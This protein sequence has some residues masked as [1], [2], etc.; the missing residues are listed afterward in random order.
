MAIPLSAGKITVSDIS[1]KLEKSKASLKT[2]SFTFTQNTYIAGSTQTVQANVFFQKPDKLKII[3]KTPQIQEIIL[4]D[5]NLYTYVPKIK[6]ITKQRT[7]LRKDVLGTIPSLFFC[8]DPLQL[9]RKR[10]DLKVID[11][12][13]KNE[14]SLIATP[15]TGE[16]FNNMLVEFDKNNCFPIRSLLKSEYLTSETIYGS[17]RINPNLS[18]EFFNVELSDDINLITID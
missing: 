8:D 6:Q 9:I 18:P 11:K 2:L 14:Y 3:Y 1:D 15:L 4:A 16:E 10:F 12:K 7:S 5:G 17:Y 13:H